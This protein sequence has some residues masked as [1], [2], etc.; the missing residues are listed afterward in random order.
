[1]T[2]KNIDILALY[3]NWRTHNWYA[4]RQSF[5]NNNDKNLIITNHALIIATTKRM[6]VHMLVDINGTKIILKQGFS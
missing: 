1:M 5:V 3:K 4:S 2:S 6:K